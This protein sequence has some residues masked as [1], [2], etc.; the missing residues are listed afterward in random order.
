MDGLKFSA[1]ELKPGSLYRVKVSFIDHERRAHA[2]G[3]SWRYES[4]DFVPYHAGLRLN[5]V[6]RG[7]PRG[8]YLQD[9]PEEQ[10]GI[11]AHF[12]EYVEEMVPPL[13]DGQHAR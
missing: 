3:E 5:V 6:D 1:F 9:Y 4:R 2:V 7:G 12:S 11:V 13:L 8:I 10:G